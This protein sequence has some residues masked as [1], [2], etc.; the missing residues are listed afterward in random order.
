MN[1]GKFRA[2]ALAVGATLGLAACSTYGDGYGYGP[3]YGAGLSYGYDGYY[4][5]Y[6]G[7]GPGYGWYDGFYYPGS[8]YYVFDRAGRRH[9]WNDR[10]RDH[11]SH[12]GGDRSGRPA[13]EGNRSGLSA[14]AQ[15][16]RREAW[17]ARRAQQG[18]AAA[19][20]ARSEARQARREAWQAQRQQQ[21]VTAPAP[22]AQRSFSG[23]GQP[24]WRGG[25]GGSW[26][27]GRRGN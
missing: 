9:A 27:G 4:D 1:A 2:A 13:W 20:N 19:P 14:E 18:T 26:R 21:G 10:Q 12:R 24:A 11:W 6:Y 3:S 16:A 8:G 7:Y 22:S 17:Q 23:G 15:Q 25:G 5:D